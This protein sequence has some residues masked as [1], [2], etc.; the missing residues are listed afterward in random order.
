MIIYFFFRMDEML[1]FPEIRNEIHSLIYRILHWIHVLE[2]Q[3]PGENDV[4]LN[5]PT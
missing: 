5:F 2:E 3:L 1:A 4:N